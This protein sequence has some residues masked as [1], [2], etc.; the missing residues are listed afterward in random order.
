MSLCEPEPHWRDLMGSDHGRVTLWTEQVE[1]HGLDL[2]SLQDL[3]VGFLDR[4]KTQRLLKQTA[5]RPTGC[6]TVFISQKS[7]MT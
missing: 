2:I 4:P 6:H 5:Q 7:A 1:H 3:Q